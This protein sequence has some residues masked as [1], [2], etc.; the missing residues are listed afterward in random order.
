MAETQSVKQAPRSLT[1]R[2]RQASVLVAVVCLV[3]T[4]VIG[5][6]AAT[7]AGADTT[8]FSS[9][10]IG[11]SGSTPT[12]NESGPWTMSWSYTCPIDVLG[13]FSATVN[14]PADATLV[15]IGPNELGGGKSGTDH[16][17]DTGTFNLA[18]SSGCSWA[19]T[20]SPASSA[21]AA[22][23][24]TITSGQVGDS[25]ETTSFFV[26]APWTMAW[27][28][29]G[30]GTSPPGVPDSCNAGLPGNFIVDVQQPL[31]GFTDDIGPNELG[32]G[33]SGVDT[34]TDA[35]TFQLII[36]SECAW[37]IT[38]TPSGGTSTPAPPAPAPKVF[39]GIAPTPDGNGY[40]IVDSQGDVY[41]KGDAV[42]HGAMTGQHLNAP[43]SHIVATPDG[44]G[45][46]MVAED[47]GIF[48]FGDAPFYGSMGGQHLNAPVVALAPT[49]DG[50]GYW[51]VASDGGIFSFGDAAF[52]GSMGGRH[53]N[54][55]IVGMA[56]DPATGGYWEVATDGGI[57]SFDAP[58]FGST[59]NIH[60]NQPIN[61]MAAM[62]DGLGYRFV[63]SDGG[64]FD[65]GDA[66]FAGSM[67]GT[68]LNAPIVGMAATPDGKGYWLVA[69]DGGVFS[70]NAPFEGSAA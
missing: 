28:Y 37:S 1:T 11:T 31:G 58:F 16:Y 26:T 17:Y 64:I 13:A 47:G 29:T 8:S 42:S 65:E 55:P 7:P 51:L 36:I 19:I 57:F 3:G 50:R 53:L 34:Y 39:T 20:V 69:S 52:Q 10:Q 24:L 27:S 4:A 41:P 61:G 2:W 59:G 60:L 49:S 5:L 48:S 9:A 46:W 45:Y 30:Q 32:S 25:G 22:T 18:V 14:Q 54:K 66:Q 70:F 68:H 38:I 35:G 40:W 63:A 12:F 62:P 15:D 6:S 67:G 21:P 43:I 56:A 44:G 33:G 23:P